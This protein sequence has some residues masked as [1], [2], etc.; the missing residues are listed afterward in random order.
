MKL[1]AVMVKSTVS[2]VMLFTVTRLEDALTAVIAPLTRAAGA[3]GVWENP[4]LASTAMD[5]K[6]NQRDFM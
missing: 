6:A 4:T 1:C 3:A 2:P 5:D